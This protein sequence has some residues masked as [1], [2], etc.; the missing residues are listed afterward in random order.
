MSTWAYHEFWLNHIWTQGLRLHH[1]DDQANWADD[2]EFNP[3]TSDKQRGYKSLAEMMEDNGYTYDEGCGCWVKGPGIHD[4]C[5]VRRP[6]HA[7][8]IEDY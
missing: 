6:A 2:T 1:V 5:P 8:P 4:F 3:F 7:M